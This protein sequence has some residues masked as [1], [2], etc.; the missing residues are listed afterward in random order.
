AHHDPRGHGARVLGP[1]PG[2]DRVGGR[3]QAPRL[4][5]PTRQPLRALGGGGA[6]HPRRPGLGRLELRGQAGNPGRG[7]GSVRDADS[8]APALPGARAAERLVR[9]G[10]AGH[11]RLVPVEVARWTTCSPS[12]P[13][14]ARASCSSPASCCCGVGACQLTSTPSRFSRRRSAP[15]LRWWATLGGRR[16]WSGG[17][18]GVF[19]V[20]GLL[21]AIK[22]IGIPILLRRM[23]RRFG[24]ERELA[25][26]VNTATSLLVGGLLVL[27]AYVVMRAGGLLS[28]R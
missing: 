17:E 11:H 15:P 1:L 20:A 4:L 13:C 16:S 21:I 2:P 19:W 14:S 7:G 3:A 6:S 27:L 10:P 8:E 12:S 23:A 18:A 26:Y 28:P 22:A 9:A 24:P 5:L 25:P